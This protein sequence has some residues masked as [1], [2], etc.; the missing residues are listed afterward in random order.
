MQ[1][2]PHTSLRQLSQQTDL[3]VGTCHKLLRKDVQ[4]YPY[5]M[6]VVPELL[7]G[8]LIQKLAFW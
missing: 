3:C 8:D 4:L 5:C 1:N 7:P 2:D 6:T